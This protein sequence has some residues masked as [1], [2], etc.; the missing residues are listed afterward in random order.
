[1]V[2]KDGEQGQIARIV[3]RDGPKEGR[4]GMA[5]KAVSKDGWQRRLASAMKRCVLIQKADV[6]V[7]FAK[8]VFLAT[9]VKMRPARTE[10]KKCRIGVNGAKEREILTKVAKGTKRC[11]P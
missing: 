5:S 8:V 6:V 11:Q 7:G 2:G 1:M 4:Q 10:F 3:G 9:G